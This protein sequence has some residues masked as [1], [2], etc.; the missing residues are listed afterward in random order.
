MSTH[1]HVVKHPHRIGCDDNQRMLQQAIAFRI[2]H[3]A[4][5]REH[6]LID[7]DIDVASTSVVNQLDRRW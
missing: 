7:P 5:R 6:V 4:R 3:R 2:V 1:D